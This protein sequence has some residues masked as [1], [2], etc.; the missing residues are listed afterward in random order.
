MLRFISISASIAV[1]AIGWWL[2]TY[3]MLIGWTGYAACKL[4]GYRARGGA[5]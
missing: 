4:V 3:L 5:W 1:L 2:T